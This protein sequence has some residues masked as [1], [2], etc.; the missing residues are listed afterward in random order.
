MKI[1]F[2]IFK[3]INII[4]LILLAISFLSNFKEIFSLK[5]ET[6]LWIIIFILSPIISIVIFQIVNKK[7]EF[8]E[9]EKR[10]RQKKE[11][12]I[13]NLSFTIF[14]FIYISL[15]FLSTSIYDIFAEELSSLNRWDLF[16][17]FARLGYGILFLLNAMFTTK[18]HKF[19]YSDFLTIDN[20]YLHEK[21]PKNW[22]KE[23][24]RFEI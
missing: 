9:W 13:L 8:F 19:L 24:K 2:N 5:Y 17:L 12:F 3:I 10:E 1:I 15:F 23:R 20:W 16:S 21:K 22:D 4:L 11:G 6:F 18:L 7:H 14:F